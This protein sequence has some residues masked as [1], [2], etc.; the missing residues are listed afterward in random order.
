MNKFIVSSKSH[1]AAAAAADA[2]ISLKI[3]V[4]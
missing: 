1:T 4:D 2:I 3:I